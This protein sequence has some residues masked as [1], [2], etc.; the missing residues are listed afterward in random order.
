MCHPDICYFDMQEILLYSGFENTPVKSGMS[1][2]ANL[3][4]LFGIVCCSS[5]PQQNVKLGITFADPEK[6]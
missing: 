1:L 6:G 4:F 5:L 3:L 2:C